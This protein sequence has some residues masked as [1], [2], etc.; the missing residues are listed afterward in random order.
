MRLFFTVVASITLFSACNSNPQP[1]AQKD[2]MGNPSETPQSAAIQVA[3]ENLATL[4]DV[5]CGMS[6]KPDNIADTALVNGRVYPFCATE[7]KKTFLADI[8]KYKLN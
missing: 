5:V 2:A 3:P 8:A 7:C 4:K 6:I 1:A